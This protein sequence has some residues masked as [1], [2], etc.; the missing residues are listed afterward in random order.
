MEL[1]IKDL[2]TVPLDHFVVHVTVLNGD[3]KLQSYV[4]GTFERNKDKLNL[5]SLLKTLNKMIDTDRSW[6]KNSYASV[7][8]F[9]QWFEPNVANFYALSG[10]FDSADNSLDH[11]LFLNVLELSRGYAVLY[12]PYHMFLNVPVDNV[13]VSYEVFYY[14]SDGFKFN[15]EIN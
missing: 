4:A 1:T 11:N 3:N 2:V 9:L 13:L 12:W 5:E 6:G 7:T 10:V 8:G 15:V 14:N